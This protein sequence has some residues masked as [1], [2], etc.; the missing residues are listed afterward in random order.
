[1]ESAGLFEGCEVDV[2]AGLDE[3]ERAGEVLKRRAARRRG[4]GRQTNI[5]KVAL[6][7]SQ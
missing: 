5:M 4:R 6:E 2:S 3:V 7:G 1:M